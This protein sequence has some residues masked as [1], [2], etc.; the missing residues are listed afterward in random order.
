[1]VRNMAKIINTRHDD[2]KPTRN[3]RGQHEGRRAFEL[4]EA[5]I[6]DINRG[7]HGENGHRWTAG[8]SGSESAQH[9]RTRR[10]EEK[11]GNKSSG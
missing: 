6:D 1:M 4:L 2:A 5:I 7:I 11:A 9:A 10:Y 8:V 3:K